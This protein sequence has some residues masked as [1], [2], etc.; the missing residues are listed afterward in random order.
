MIEKS[1]LADNGKIVELDGNRILVDGITVFYTPPE[2]RM[3]DYQ[4]Y[5]D[6]NDGI[7]E[8]GG[9]T[10]AWSQGMYDG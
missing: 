10:N 8:T 4:E 7:R 1:Y 3:R 6:L 5:C 2:Q 9:G